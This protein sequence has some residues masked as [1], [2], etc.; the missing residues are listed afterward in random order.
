MNGYLHFSQ[1]VPRP[2]DSVVPD[3]QSQTLAPFDRVSG[4][5]P[6]VV[7]VEAEVAGIVYR[8]GGR[9]M[10]ITEMGASSS[11]AVGEPRSLADAAGTTLG[12]LTVRSVQDPF[13]D[14]DPNGP[15]AEGMRYVVLDAAFEAAEDQ[16]L[17]ASPGNVGLVAADGRLFWPAWVPRPQPF[18]LQNLESQPLSPGDR[19]SGVI[20][21]AVPQDVVLDSVVYNPESNR[22]VALVDL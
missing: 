3:L 1:W 19:V 20:G 12:S 21:F 5:I 2:A 18:V 10:P 7:P 17:Q 11:V 16:P 6:Y 9:L 4:V 13:T 22:F 14:H 8:G 15:P